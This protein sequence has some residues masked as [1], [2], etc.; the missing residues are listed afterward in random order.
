MEFIKGDYF[1][2]EFPELFDGIITDIPYEAHKDNELINTSQWIFDYKS[3]M[4]KT[5]RE[6]KHDA[7]L[8]TFCNLLAL[9][10]LK[11]NQGNWI[12]HAYQIWNKNRTNWIGFDRPLRQV[13]F[14][15]YFKKGDFKFNFRN[16]LKSKCPKRS[17]IGLHSNDPSRSP[18]LSQGTYPEVL[19]VNN[20]ID[21]IHKFEKPLFF[22]SMFFKIV[23]DKRVLDPFCGTG[24]LLCAFEHGTGV[25]IEECRMRQFNPS[26]QSRQSKVI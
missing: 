2:I 8:I 3:F 10:D 13:E 19:S 24:S 26:L 7:F 5:S 9:I 20:L 11:I 15:A 16:D 14:I 21:K 17:Q 22:T 6:T 12:F 23:G 18:K 25:D 1:K 4:D